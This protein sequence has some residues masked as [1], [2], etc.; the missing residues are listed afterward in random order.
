M[1][2]IIKENQIKKLIDMLISEQDVNI[3]RGG[4]DLRTVSHSYLTKNH[5][6]PDGANHENYYYRA[7]VEDVINQS[8]TG[9]IENFLSVFNPIQIYNK[10]KDAYLDY[11]DVNGDTLTQKDMSQ[12]VRKSFRFTTG[13][14]TASHNGLLAIARAMDSLQGKGGILTL[15]FGQYKTGEE[16]RNERLTGNVIYQSS[17]AFNQRPHVNGLLSMLVVYSMK[18]E[19]R[20][21]TATLGYA[22]AFK[23]NNQF[24]T[25][26]Q[27]Y[28]NNIII[29]ANGFFDPNN[30]SIKDIVDELGPKG[31]ITQTNFDIKP[32]LDELSSLQ[33]E[34]DV[35]SAFGVPYQ[36]RDKK[37]DYNKNKQAKLRAISTKYIPNLI[38]DIKQK[39]IHNFKI[40][41]ENYLQEVK[42]NI[43]PTIDTKVTFPI[44]NLAETHWDQITGTGGQAQQPTGV[45]SSSNRTYD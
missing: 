31:L 12:K 1:K 22:A 13:T 43:L 42:A 15:Q 26:I 27:N 21:Y 38:A 29:G 18:P 45:L 34:D 36:D 2:L 41:V 9:T 32:L 4:T 17:T 39:Y 40:F 14:I 20:K 19:Y 5:G 24:A 6:L 28:I 44:L 7:N 8:K 3:S 10:N 33:Q 37:K 35:L 23:D 30:K 11:V 25:Y 16:A